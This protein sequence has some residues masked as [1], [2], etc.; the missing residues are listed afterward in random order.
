MAKQTES[1]EVRPIRALLR[2]LIHAPAILA[3]IWPMFLLIGSYAAYSNWYSS[4]LASVHG[5]ILP[6][7]III[8]EAPEY[9]RGDL[10]KQVYE[11]AQ[12]DLLSPLDRSATAKLASAFENHA[13]V[14]DVVTARKLPGGK[15]Q[16]DLNYRELVAAFHVT[17]GDAWKAG[18]ADHL[19]SMNYP[20]S[21]ASGFLPLDGEGVLLP[22]A[23]LTLEDVEKLIHIEVYELYPTGDQ[24]TL[25]GDRRVESAA[26]LAKLLSAVHDQVKV[27]KIT[28]SGN[29]SVN[30]IPRL[31]LVL[32]DGTPVTWGSPPGMEQP[33]ERG[34]R[35]K[36]VDLLRGNYVKG[37]DLSIARQNVQPIR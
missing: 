20:A 31:D 27:S 1:S 25:F 7:H 24:G 11:T 9:I 15:F 13:W 4:H 12:L 36:L 10:V 16:V 5:K 22:T 32:A 34:A 8:D 18:I 33:A 3:L 14:S 29:P 28:V 19:R 35:D 6:E 30:R 26:L 21:L 23:G 2:R 37:A 17:G